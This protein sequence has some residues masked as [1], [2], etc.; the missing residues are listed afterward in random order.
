LTKR[1]RGLVRLAFVAE[2]SVLSASRSRAARPRR[3]RFKSDAHFARIAGVAS[4]P[5]PPV[6]MIG[7]AWTAAAI[8]SS[9]ALCMSSRSLAGDADP[10]TGA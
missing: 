7:L 3:E 10:Q 1:D 5:V 9:T 8:P 4:I 6:A 2:W